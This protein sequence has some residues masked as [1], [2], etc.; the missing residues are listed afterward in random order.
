[1]SVSLSIFMQEGASS[2]REGRRG[3]AADPGSPG[4]TRLIEVGKWVTEFPRA[5]PHC[6]GHC[7]ILPMPLPISRPSPPSRAT[8][9]RGTSL[10]QEGYRLALI[11]LYRTLL[12]AGAPRESA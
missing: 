5:P 2:E 7:A 3:A 1:C 11:S 10:P 6:H 12:E 4:L 9:T 8:P